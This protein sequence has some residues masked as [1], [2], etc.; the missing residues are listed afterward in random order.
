MKNIITALAILLLLVA[1]SVQADFAKV[2]SAGAQFLKMGVGPRYQAMGDAAVAIVD[3]IYAAY[4]N[5]AGLAEIDNSAVGFTNVNWVLDINLNY[6]ALARY[7]EDVGTFAVSATVLSMGDQE[8]TTFENQT[9]TGDYYSATSYAVGVSY[10]RQLTNRFSFGGTVKY[11]GERIHNESA[12]GFA[13]DFGTLLHTGYRSLRLGMS[14]SNMGPE[15]DFN[16]PDLDVNYD[17]LEGEGAN[18]GVGAQVKTTPYNLPMVFRV[19]MA[20]D[21]EMGPKS[22][23]TLAGELKHPNDNLQHG[24]IGAEYSFSQQFF[25]RG[26]YKFNYDEETLALGAG[27]KTAV[28]SSTRLFIDYSWQDLGRLQ[29][30][31]RFSVGFTF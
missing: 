21:I 7:F 28:S 20:Y 1:G 10:A 6:F 13:F 9:G 8:I 12:N 31:Q 14:I 19:G 26:G 29:N 22:I 23:V 30:S 18:D 24:V 27:L 2:G 3:D 17:A 4:W 15:M 11:I 16:G 5:P 25:L